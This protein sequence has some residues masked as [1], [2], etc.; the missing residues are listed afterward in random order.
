[1]PAD[2]FPRAGT[3]FPAGAADHKGTQ[4]Q[5]NMT[6]DH[7]TCDRRSREQMP[8][9][10]VTLNSTLLTECD[11]PGR[12]LA[13]SSDLL[14]NLWQHCRHNI[15][16][17]FGLRDSTCRP[18][19]PRLASARTPCPTA[20]DASVRVSGA[21]TIS[22]G[23]CGGRDRSCDRSCQQPAECRLLRRR[24]VS[25]VGQPQTKP[26]RRRADR[27]RETNT[28]TEYCRCPSMF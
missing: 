4:F 25:S 3:A 7:A 1:V 11:R 28:G 20:A 24:R 13:A 9:A 15:M 17:C 27:S 14:I 5:T 26:L 19:R 12:L 6:G 2:I 10:L 22:A 18:A 21:T 16:T 8:A 23:L